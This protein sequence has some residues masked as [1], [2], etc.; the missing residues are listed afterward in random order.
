MRGAR[1][2]LEDARGLLEELRGAR[3]GL[4]Q[5][6][7]HELDEAMETLGALARAAESAIVGVTAEAT[8]RGV[9]AASRCASTTQWVRQRA[10]EREPGSASAVALLATASKGPDGASLRTA[11]WEDGIG[12]RLAARAV[13]EARRTT[14]LVPN[15]DVSEITGHYLDRAAAS[16]GSQR[17]MDQLTREIIARYGDD[18]LD[19][20]DERARQVNSLTTSRR[21]AGRVRYTLELC[22]PDAARFDAAIAGLSGPR[23]ETGT[24][25]EDAAGGPWAADTTCGLDPLVTDHRSPAQRRA[26]A[27]LELLERAQAEDSRAT[28]GG[29]GL[30]GSTTLIVTADAAALRE[31][32]EERV[33][34]VGD[35][36]AEGTS[37]I[38]TGPR[39]RSGR[40]RGWA[41]GILPAADAGAASFGTTHTGEV[42]TAGQLRRMA[43]DADVLP[44]VLG[45]P[46]APLDTG[47]VHRL[48]TPE[49]RAALATRDGG[50]TAPG[51]DRPPGWCD[52]HH[53]RHWAD[54]GETALHNLT[55]LCRRHHT[56]V[57]R[58][59]LVATVRPDGVEWRDPTLPEAGGSVD[60]P[61][62]G[63]WW[64]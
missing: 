24:T 6:Q 62:T 14:P 30:S 1:E 26:E 9:V 16:D 10:G 49:M 11:L 22:V 44:Q 28:A 18:V 33:D 61:R 59:G 64:A 53:I 20:M 55:L 40:G 21:M 12:V 41:R 17:A 13:R 50:C 23:P 48:A 52:A 3:E 63:A 39:P 32:L 57:H 29:C 46:S 2:V 27:L 58:D 51:C 36:P 8:E 34:E 37:S 60:P 31:A 47:R 43:C 38:L 25:G 4:W 45:G 5:V 19:E 35:L 42:L 54:G 15:A 56:I 7:D